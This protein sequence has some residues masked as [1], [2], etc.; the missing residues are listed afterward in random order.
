MT[1]VIR[2]A[3]L[4]VLATPISGAVAQPAAA[5]PAGSASA[6]VAAGRLPYR[7]DFEGYRGFTDQPVLSWREANDRVGRIGGWQA[8]ARDSQNGAAGA[9][10]A[11][12]SPAERSGHSGH[13]AR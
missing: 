12:S 7:S 3:M 6:A 1:F 5:A 9:P 4:A 8:Y 13:H 10:P 11:A 2:A